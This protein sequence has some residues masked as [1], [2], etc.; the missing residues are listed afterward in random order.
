MPSREK[1]REGPLVEF[2]RPLSPVR[3]WGD[4]RR[5]AAIF[6]CFSRTTAGFSLRS[7]LCGGAGSLAL[8]V[9]CPNCLLTGNLT[10]NLANSGALKPHFLSLSCTFQKETSGSAISP[11]RE[12]A[13]MYQGI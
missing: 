1:G 3:F 11:S 2:N 13:G 5:I 10:G 12:F 6:S 4:N 8:T 7:R 9:L